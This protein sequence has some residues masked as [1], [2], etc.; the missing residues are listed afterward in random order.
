V[1]G[2]SVS[3]ITALLSKEYAKGVLAA[4]II[5]WPV[6]D[7]LMKAWLQDYHYRIKLGFPL[8]LLAA[9][10]SLAIAQLTVIFQALKAARTDPSRSLRCE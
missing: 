3:G 4:N 1:M 9:G 2:A 8:F 7:L 5:A 6:A 10:L